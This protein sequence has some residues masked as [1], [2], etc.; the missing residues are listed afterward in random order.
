MALPCILFPSAITNSL[1]VMLM[2]TIAEIQTSKTKKELADLIKKVTAACFILGLS[3]CLFFLLTGSFIGMTLFNSRTAG[4]FIV[5]LAWMCPFLY[6][7]SALLSVINGFGKTG[8]TFLINAAGLALRI[9][10][11][12]YGIPRFGIRGYLWGLLLSQFTVT[13]FAVFVISASVSH[14]KTK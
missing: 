1:S 2:P 3:C 7:N 14:C 12:F 6:T 9:G 10:S 8:S 13:L 4:K 5:T 11:V